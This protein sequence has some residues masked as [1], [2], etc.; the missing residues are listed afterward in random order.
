MAST[1]QPARQRPTLGNV[2]S[3]TGLRGVAVM[4]VLLSHA[5]VRFDGGWIGVDV[6]FALSGFLITALLLKEVQ[7]RGGVSLARFYERRIL[8]LWP[9][10]FAMLVVYALLVTVVGSRLSDPGLWYRSALVSVTFR[11]DVGGAHQWALAPGLGHTWSLA[12]EEQFYVVWALVVAACALMRRRG[13]V[14]LAVV[15]VVGIVATVAYRESL[16]LR[17]AKY[18]AMYFSPLTR[19]DALLVG[20]AAAQLWWAGWTVPRWVARWVP[21]LAAVAIVGVGLEVSNVTRWVYS[22]PIT[23]LDALFALLVLVLATDASSFA[24][25][26]LS[27]R[28]IVWLG[29]I[30]YSLYLWHYPVFA[31]VNPHV[32]GPAFPRGVACAGISIGVAAVS[33]R[34]VEVPFLRLKDRIAA[35]RT[36]PTQV[37][38]GVV[39]EGVAPSVSA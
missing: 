18:S 27:G 6:F 2:E 13:Q 14:L 23:V 39:P 22:G 5:T 8:R 7:A 21:A 38:P 29:L 28:T 24:A 35:S 34:Y 4:A 37:T 17:G 15:T 11:Y 31:V 26:V 9:A 1:E 32:P 33:R 12:M 30:S 3:L 36:S 25:R 20:C 10:F 16:Y 19:A